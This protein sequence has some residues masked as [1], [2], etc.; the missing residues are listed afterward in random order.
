MKKLVKI[1][2]STAFFVI[3]IVVAFQASD[4]FWWRIMDLYE[5]V[6]NG[7]IHF[8]GKF[9]GFW[10]FN[11]IY[12]LSFGFAFLLSSFEFAYLKM[13]KITKNLFLQLSIFTLIII[14]ISFLDANMRLATCTMCDDGILV[15]ERSEINYVL[16]LSFS[17]LCSSLPTI[18]RLTRSRH[19]RN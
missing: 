10:G 6:S 3:G 16:I 15:L 11:P 1:S 8:R 19:N 9:A 14:C 7:N 2:I 18:I 4:F 13:T 5:W 12:F 17:I